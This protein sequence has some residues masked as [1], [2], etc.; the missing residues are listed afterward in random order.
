MADYIKL[1]SLMQRINSRLCTIIGHYDINII[2][3]IIVTTTHS[4]NG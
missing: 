1:N 4:N 3:V 2:A